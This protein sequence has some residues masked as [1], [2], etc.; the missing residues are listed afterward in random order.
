MYLGF[1]YPMSFVHPA[2]TV[3]LL[4]CITQAST[5]QQTQFQPEAHCCQHKVSFC[6]AIS[7]SVKLLGLGLIPETG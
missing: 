3:P 2:K 6:K 5:T 4:S 7:T 1:Y